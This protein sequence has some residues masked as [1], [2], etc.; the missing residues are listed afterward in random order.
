ML[1]PSLFPAGP[2]HFAA[3][4]PGMALGE[5]QLRRATLHAATRHAALPERACVLAALRQKLLAGDAGAATAAVAIAGDTAG[6]APDPAHGRQLRAAEAAGI[7][8]AY[9]SLSYR[10][11]EEAVREGE[12]DGLGRGGAGGRAALLERLL[13]AAAASAASSE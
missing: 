2:S 11:W 10:E 7:P 12:D 3:N 9:A 13:S 6:D 1:T 4:V 5:T 8:L